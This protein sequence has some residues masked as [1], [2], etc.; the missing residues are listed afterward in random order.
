MIPTKVEHLELIP[1]GCYDRTVA[2]YT[3]R[4]KA[5]ELCEAPPVLLRVP[6]FGLV[7][8]AAHAIPGCVAPKGRHFEVHGLPILQPGHA[9]GLDAQVSLA[10]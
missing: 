4:N 9:T 1:S 5:V 6:E 7:S 3:G 2:F 8:D 10:A